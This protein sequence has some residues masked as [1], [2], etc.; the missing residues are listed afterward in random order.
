MSERRPVVEDELHALVDGRLDPERRVEVEAWLDRHPEARA[1]VQAWASGREAL[2]AALAPVADE[3]L[4]GRLNLRRMAAER[5]PV[6]AFSLH[7]AAAAMVALGVGAGA[8]WGARGLD[9]TPPRGVVAL[10]REAAMSFRTFARDPVRPVEIEAA[11]RPELVAWIAGRL[12]R[13]VAP[14]DLEAAGYRLLGGRIVPTA[15]GPGGLFLYGGQGEAR[16]A[17]YV[18]PMART[19]EAARMR[20]S[21]DGELADVAWADDGLGFSVVGSSA[22]RELRALAQSVRAQATDTRNPA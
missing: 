5:R 2:A 13:R 4:P 17:V 6:R 3:P 1:R 20:D 19:H 18:R 12:H 14:P 10:G 8:G 9:P 15:H 21:R 7:A 22:P 16:L 11:Q